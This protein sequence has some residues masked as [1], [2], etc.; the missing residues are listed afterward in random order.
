M[1]TFEPEY[2][3]RSGPAS[4]LRTTDH[5]VYWGLVLGAFYLLS[6]YGTEDLYILMTLSRALVVTIIAVLPATI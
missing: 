5:Q 2:V 6:A 3:R 1:A 4:A